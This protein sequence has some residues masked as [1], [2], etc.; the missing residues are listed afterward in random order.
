MLE[1]WKLGV[2]QPGAATV[3]R[4]ER[5]IQV[6]FRLYGMFAHGVRSAPVMLL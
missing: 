5:L 4:Y 3:A 1:R 6:H 2:L